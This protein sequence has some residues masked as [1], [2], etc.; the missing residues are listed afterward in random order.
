MEGIMKKKSSLEILK[1]QLVKGEID[2][3]DMN[4]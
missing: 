4:D 1:E 3:Q 2:E